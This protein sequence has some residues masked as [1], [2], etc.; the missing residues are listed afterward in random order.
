MGDGRITVF[1]ADDN[2]IVRE[3][4]RALLALEPDLE[5][6]G[7]AADYDELIAGAEAAAP[8]VLVTDIRMPPELPERGHRRGQ[9]AAQAPPRHRRGRALAV[10]RPRVRD[11]A[12]RRRRR[13][14]TP[15]CSRTASPRATSSRAPCARSRPAARC[16]TRRSSRRWCSR[17][18]TTPASPRPRS[19]SSTRSPRAGRSRPS[20][21]RSGTTPAAV[22][23]EVEELFLKLVARARAPAPPAR[24]KR[25]RML[26]TAIVD[27]EEQ[28]E[29]LSRLLPGGLAEK[30][31]DE[32][33]AIG[34]T[35]ELVVTVL[36]SD[37]RGYSAIAERSDPTR[38]RGAAQRAP[39]RDEPGDPRRG[40]HGDAVRRRRG[41]GGVR[42][43]GPARRPRRPRRRRGRARCSNASARSTSGGSPRAGAVRARHRPVDRPGRG[44]AA[45]FGGAARVHAGRR[46]GEPGAAAAGPRPAGGPDRAQR[47][48]LR[49]RCTPARV[50]AARRD[51]GQGAELAG[52]R[53]PHRRV[54]QHGTGTGR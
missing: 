9:G 34:E 18:P 38:A 27:R 52:A 40:R 37:I 51:D 4:V 5:V 53:V 29:T 23:D 54:R 32:G 39:G 6:V 28:G 30:V 13:R 31:R 24:C 15:T 49:A 16:S 26:H 47:E 36:M 33:R 21:T 20:P 10:R 19:S 43:A 12:A 42:R 2:V 17:S 22:A 25:L 44:R 45:R 35:E 8:Q 1:L 41:D 3:G 48:H 14:A 7:T 46:H 50:R 11:R